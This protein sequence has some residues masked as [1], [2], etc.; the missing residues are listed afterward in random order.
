MTCIHRLQHVKG[1]SASHLAHDDAIRPHAQRVA[2]ER[3]YRDLAFP[4]NIGRSGLERNQ[5]REDTLSRTIDG[6]KMQ[7]GQRAILPAD[8]LY[9]NKYHSSDK[10]GYVLK[11]PC[12]SR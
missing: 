2:N 12:L 5:V 1:F 8:L 4:F 11:T 10:E 9:L 7:H 3:S 6:I